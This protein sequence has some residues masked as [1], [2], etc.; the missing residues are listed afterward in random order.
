VA[1]ACLIHRQAGD[2]PELPRPTRATGADPGA[3]TGHLEPAN[4]SAAL[5]RQAK[6]RDF[7]L[8]S[9]LQVTVFAVV[10][11][12]SWPFKATG[13]VVYGTLVNHYERDQLGLAVGRREFDGVAA[14]RRERS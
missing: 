1:D 14:P 7:W 4:S 10:C 2:P 8:Q 5:L 11:T 6:E 9:R 12:G 3:K 13:Q